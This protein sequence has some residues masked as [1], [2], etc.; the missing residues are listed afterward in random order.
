MSAILSFRNDCN[1]SDKLWKKFNWLFN[2]TDTD[3]LSLIDNYLV[4]LKIVSSLF[5]GS[6]LLGNFVRDFKMFCTFYIF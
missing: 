2:I 5:I 4:N 1:L 3:R 6:V